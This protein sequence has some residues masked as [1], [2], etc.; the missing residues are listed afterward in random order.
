M[1]TSSSSQALWPWICW[2]L[3]ALALLVLGLVLMPTNDCSGEFERDELADGFVLVVLGLSFFGC[4]AAGIWSLAK[5]EGRPPPQ[6]LAVVV[7]GVLL[8]LL[9][10]FFGGLN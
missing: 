6:V 4:L 7:A 3:L 2:P 1:R 10:V 5:L 9:A 8:F